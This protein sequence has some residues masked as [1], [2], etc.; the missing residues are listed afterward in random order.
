[1]PFAHTHTLIMVKSS[2]EQATECLRILHSH[3]E[4]EQQE[5]EQEKE[6]GQKGGQH[7]D[8]SCEHD[9]S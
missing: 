1:M 7:R 9:S 2:R 3:R 4:Q 5:A 6:Q 8:L